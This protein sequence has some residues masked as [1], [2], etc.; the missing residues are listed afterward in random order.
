MAGL[1]LQT[2]WFAETF[3]TQDFQ[4]RGFPIKDSADLDLVYYETLA[5][6]ALLACLPQLAGA[7]PVH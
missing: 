3:T 2:I 1:R 6:V 4:K 5:Q 7:S